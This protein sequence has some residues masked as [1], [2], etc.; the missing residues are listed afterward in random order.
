MDVMDEVDAEEDL[1]RDGRR[2]D[3]EV[4]DLE[5]QVRRDVRAPGVLDHRLVDVETQKPELGVFVGK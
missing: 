2:P 1:G 4:G 5:G 3:L